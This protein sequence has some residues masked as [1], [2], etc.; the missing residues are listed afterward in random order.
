MIMATAEKVNKSQAI[1]DYL[2]RG[3]NLE[4]TTPSKIV[5]AL[6]KK[7]IKVSSPLAAQVLYKERG[8]LGGGEKKKK[9]SER[10]PRYTM[11]R[12]GGAKSPAKQKSKSSEPIS[13]DDL[14]WAKDYADSFGGAARLRE[15]LDALEE[16]QIG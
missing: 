3:R 15:V 2:K 8:T 14:Q 4:T 5:E 9:K 6:A 7:G 10:K 11:T 12:K 16:V 13:Y 1:R